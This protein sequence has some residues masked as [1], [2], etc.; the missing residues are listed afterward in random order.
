M[1]GVPAGLVRL[2]ANLIDVKSP[3]T[4]AEPS[5]VSVV[6]NGSATAI[7]AHKATMARTPTSVDFIGPWRL[8]SD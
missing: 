2:G 7:G 6:K 8:I 3:T 1:Q 4:L 5:A